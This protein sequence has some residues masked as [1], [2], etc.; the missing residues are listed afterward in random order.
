MR[1]VCI[2]DTHGQH[3]RITVPDGDVLI[4]A[5]DATGLGRIHELL[6]FDAWLGELPHKHKFFVPGNH[7]RCFQREPW[8]RGLLT[9]AQLLLDSGV[10]FFHERKWTI[11][12][13]PWTLRFMNWAF[14]V[15]SEAELLSKYRRVSDGWD[16]VVTHGPPAGT[17]DDGKGS[18]A[19]R[20]ILK[21]RRPLLHV[22]G[23][24]HEGYGQQDWMVNASICDGENRVTN[25]PIVVDLAEVS[26]ICTEGE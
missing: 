21:K 7:D 13:T 16:I 5:G 23:H 17:L 14:L 22:F 6:S 26:K 18:T 20:T 2:A 25:E 15:D 24:I 12:G 4:H 19:L 1:V 10:T 11:Y 3:D 9:N 8:V